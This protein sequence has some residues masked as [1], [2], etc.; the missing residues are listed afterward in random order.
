MDILYDNDSAKLKAMIMAE[1]AV[2]LTSNLQSIKKSTKED[3][4]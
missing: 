2:S 1:G 4:F 3:L